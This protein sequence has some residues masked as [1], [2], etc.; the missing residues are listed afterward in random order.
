MDE[1]LAALDAL[2]QELAEAK[3][4]CDER[5]REGGEPLED[6][7]GGGLEDLIPELADI[8]RR[9]WMLELLLRVCNM[10]RL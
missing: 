9:K 3:E 5:D 6:F 7:L 8:C 10:R 4:L 1:L 2:E